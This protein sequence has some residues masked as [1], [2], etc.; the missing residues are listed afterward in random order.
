M[1]AAVLGNGIHV[2]CDPRRVPSD[3]VQ[4]MERTARARARDEAKSAELAEAARHVA[5]EEAARQAEAAQR[6]AEV[7]AERA[8]EGWIVGVRAWF[9][10]AVA[11]VVMIGRPHSS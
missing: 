4:V 8:A 7:E 6:A 5:A 11:L 10:T 9:T 2:S 3:A 1:R